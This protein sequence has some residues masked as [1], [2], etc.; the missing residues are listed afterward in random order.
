MANPPLS[1]EEQAVVARLTDIDRQ[2][3]D[4]AILANSSDRWLKVARVVAW[5]ESALKDRYPGLSY[6]FYLLITHESLHVP[7]SLISAFQAAFRKRHELLGGKST[8]SAFDK[9]YS[10]DFEE[11]KR[12]HLNFFNAK[13]ELLRANYYA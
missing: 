5:T 7:V 6:I 10:A 3:I 12:E 1:P 8:R 11:A 2:A 9:A 13:E 4:A